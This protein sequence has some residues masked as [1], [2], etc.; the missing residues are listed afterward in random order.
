VLQT[1][2]APERTSAL[3]E[4]KEWL[5][6][7]LADGPLTAEDVSD[8]AKA[9]GISEKTLQRAS[10]ALK[11]QKRKLGMQGPWSWSL[12]PKMAKAPEDTQISD[13]ATFD[14][15]GHLRETDTTA[16][17]QHGEQPKEGGQQP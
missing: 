12:P 13:V 17:L 8:W 2:R 4:A 14:K 11:V 1:E 16:T 6:D 7:A 9:N 10:K 15:I 5:Q 3:D